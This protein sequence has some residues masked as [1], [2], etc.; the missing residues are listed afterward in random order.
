MREEIVRAILTNLGVKP[1]SDA[2]PEH[3][4]LKNQ[5]NNGLK[6]NMTFPKASLVGGENI[7]ALVQ[8][9]RDQVEIVYFPGKSILVREGERNPG[10]YYVLDGSLVAQSSM[11]HVGFGNEQNERV[12]IS[13]IWS[14]SAH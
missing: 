12:G 11:S 3:Q 4:K 14:I 6:I 8:E 1:R 13:P 2:K 7:E 9:Y 10:L 5:M